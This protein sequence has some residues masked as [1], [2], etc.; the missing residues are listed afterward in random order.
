[1]ERLKE[2]MREA[3]KLFERMNY[4]DVGEGNYLWKDGELYIGGEGGDTLISG[5]SG[6]W[7]W[8]ETCKEDEAKK[9]AEYWEEQR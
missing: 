3:K 5:A 8:L 4:F 9:E 1:M 2:V 6:K 7:A